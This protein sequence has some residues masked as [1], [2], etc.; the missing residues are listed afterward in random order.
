[1]FQKQRMPRH[2]TV[3]EKEY[4]HT[5]PEGF[6]GCFERVSFSLIEEPESCDVCIYY[7]ETDSVCTCGKPPAAAN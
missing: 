7:R 1:M 5:E 2:R 3:M 4:P 6:C